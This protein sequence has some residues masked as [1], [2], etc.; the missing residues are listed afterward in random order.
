M[1]IDLSRL[2]KDVALKYD[3]S[4]FLGLKNVK[5]F[6]E[7]NY[8]LFENLDLKSIEDSQIIYGYNSLGNP[9]K[10]GFDNNLIQRI[11]IVTESINYR[12]YKVSLAY[13]GH[14]YFGFQI[15]NNQRTIQGE[16]SKIITKINCYDTLVQGASRT[17][18]G[19]HAN[20]MVVHFDT[21]RNLDSEKWLE[22]L[23]HQ[24]PKDILVKSV[25][26]VHPL[27]HSRYDVYMK[28][29]VY[30]IRLNE[31]DPLRINYEWNVQNINIQ[32]L[33]TNI[34]QLVGKH[35]FISF[36]KGNPDTSIRTIYKTEIVKSEQGIDLVFEGNGFLRYMIRLIVFALVQIST[37]NLNMEIKDILKERSRTH[38][39]H[40]AP[41]TGLYLD[42]IT[43]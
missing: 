34:N 28:R 30:K 41:A 43:Y 15:Q 38:T 4:I 42:K 10:L 2:H 6:V 33:E 5:D 26:E 3:K 17:D 19:V 22:V 11:V 14:D 20:N 13:D 31:V 39:K 12:R 9:F 32:T 36:C 23:N 40:M 1:N 29:Y 35:D 18:T 25:E 24:L 27:F 16:L 37:D 21:D 8:M 7:S